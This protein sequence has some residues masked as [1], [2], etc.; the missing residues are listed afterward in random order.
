MRPR[1]SHAGVGLAKIDDV[2]ALGK[3]LIEQKGEEFFLARYVDYASEDGL[4]RK[5]RVVV[6]DGKP[7]ACHMAI[8]DRGTSGTSTPA[9]R[10]ARASGWRKRPSCR[11]ST[12][13]SGC[14]IAPR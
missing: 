11:P 6:A 9:C 4:F 10:K 3:Y 7:Y 2:F 1:G 5:Y 14:A 8:A 12:S 13:A